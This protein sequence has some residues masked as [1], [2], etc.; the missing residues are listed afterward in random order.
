MDET[1]ETRQKGLLFAVRR[2]IRYHSRRR[3]FFE[4][5]HRTT[6]AAGIIL[7]SAVVVAILANGSDLLAQVAAGI[8]A[9]LS[10]VD[11]VVGTGP[12]ART[13]HDL[14]RRFSELERRLCCEETTDE[15]LNGVIAERLTIEVD[16]PPT[17]RVLDTLCHNELLRACNAD[18][19]YRVRVKPMQ[20]WV[21]QLFDWNAEALDYETPTLPTT[22]S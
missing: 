8:V 1:I 11:L 6:S 2:S 7:S 9:V 5:W 18:K 13:H 3:G 10:A 21:S 16:E 4:R 14:V 19:K 17:L 20:R 15:T 12:M 22:S